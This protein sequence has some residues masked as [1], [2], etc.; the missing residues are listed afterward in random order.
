MRRPARSPFGTA[1]LEAFPTAH[2]PIGG[3]HADPAAAP[4][5]P[6]T[7]GAAAPSGSSLEAVRTVYGGDDMAHWRQGE[8]RAARLALAGSAA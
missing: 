7:V 3:G 8:L 5:H 4:A 2:N 1:S 6:Q